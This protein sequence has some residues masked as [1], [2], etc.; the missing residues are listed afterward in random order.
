MRFSHLCA[1]CKQ[2]PFTESCTSFLPFTTELARP[3]SPSFKQYLLPKAYLSLHGTFTKAKQW[4]SRNTCCLQG[5]YSLIFYVK[6]IKNFCR[7]FCF[8]LF[9]EK[10]KQTLHRSFIRLHKLWVVGKSPHC[11]WFTPSPILSVQIK[12]WRSVGSTFSP[13]VLHA[14]V[15]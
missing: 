9:I 12:Q 8:V 4:S 14:L 5:H 1:F 15:K 11:V 7:F 6:Y 2:L 3:L 10:N 13:E